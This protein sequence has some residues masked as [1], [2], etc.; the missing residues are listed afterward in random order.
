MNTLT[1]TTFIL[2]ADGNGQTR[3]IVKNVLE[4]EDNG[5]FR[6]EEVTDG[7]QFMERLEHKENPIDIAILDIRLPNTDVIEALV[8][9]YEKWRGTYVIVSSIE[10]DRDMILDLQNNY[11][12]WGYLI[13]GRADYKP[14]LE[15]LVYAANTKVLYKK[16]FIMQMQADA[17]RYQY[18]TADQ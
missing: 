10:G 9:L 12:I 13:K 1:I 3:D 17:K 5:N 8:K 14:N 7:K 15:R 4:K 6:L 16:Q 11:H 18:A 2:N